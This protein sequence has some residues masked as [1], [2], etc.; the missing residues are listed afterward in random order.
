MMTPSY[1]FRDDGERLLRFFT[2][3]SKP[4]GVELDIYVR[5][6]EHTVGGDPYRD[7][8]FKIRI[9]LHVYKPI[10]INKAR[11]LN[12]IENT[13]NGPVFAFIDKKTGKPAFALTLDIWFVDD[14]EARKALAA[15]NDEELKESNFVVLKPGKDN[16]VDVPAQID[17]R[18][19]LGEDLDQW[20][21]RRL[22]IEVLE[23]ERFRDVPF[24][25]RPSWTYIARAIATS[26]HHLRRNTPPPRLG[27]IV[28]L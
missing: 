4:T 26:V 3:K 19:L 2:R 21:N 7:L 27:W 5:G 8:R 23:D 1:L 9:T 14:L 16:A 20:R 11:V 15:V 28:L 10:Y 24:R 12:G 25:S 22:Q 13:A 6:D 17:V 18:G